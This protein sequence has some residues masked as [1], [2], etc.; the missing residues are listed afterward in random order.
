MIQPL[1][2]CLF[3]GPLH[4][5]TWLELLKE[6][7]PGLGGIVVLW[8]PSTAATVQTKAVAQATQLLKVKIDIMEVKTAVNAK[9]RTIV[10]GRETGVQLDAI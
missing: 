7:V 2:E 6:A 10:L 5:T 9:S 8:D 4:A 1:R 3:L